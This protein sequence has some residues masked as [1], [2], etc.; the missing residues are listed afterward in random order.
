MLVGLSFISKLR[1]WDQN[2]SNVQFLGIAHTSYINVTSACGIIQNIFL[3]LEL[4]L[5]IFNLAVVLS[6]GSHHLL[7]FFVAITHVASPKQV[8]YTQLAQTLIPLTF[9]HA[10]KPLLTL[11]HFFPVFAVQYFKESTGPYGI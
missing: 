8:M 2:I 4:E 6:A 5:L 3:T 9:T 7:S 11:H 10:D 1:C